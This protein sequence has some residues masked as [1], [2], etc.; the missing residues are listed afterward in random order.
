MT[1]TARH[2]EHT[3]NGGCVLR[4]GKCKATITR[5]G[6]DRWCWWTFDPRGH[7]GENS[8]AKTRPEAMREAFGS[9]LM[10]GWT[11]P[12]RWQI[13]RPTREWPRLPPTSNVRLV[14]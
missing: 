7:G 14:V 12:R 13:G 5:S 1:R 10:Q 3:G 4:L 8:V 11:D 9:L 2:W 6:E